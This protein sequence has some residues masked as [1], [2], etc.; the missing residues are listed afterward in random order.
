MKLHMQDLYLIQFVMKK[1]NV[2]VS[3]ILGCILVQTSINRK[4]DIEI[5]K[6][7]LNTQS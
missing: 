2:S 7:N 6:E 4:H 1:I 3:V 5:V